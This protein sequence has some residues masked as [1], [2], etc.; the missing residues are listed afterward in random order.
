[1]KQKMMQKQRENS[2]SDGR[3]YYKS[4]LPLFAD[5]AEGKRFEREQMD[6]LVRREW[7]TRFGPGREEKP[8]AA[9]DMGVFRL[10]LRHAG[11]H[12]HQRQQGGGRDG[13]GADRA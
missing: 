9:E 2:Y 4:P 12:T 6:M 11:I 10:V 1:M 13:R 3:Q 8:C 5:K 7:A